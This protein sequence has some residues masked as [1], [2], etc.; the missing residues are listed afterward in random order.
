MDCQIWVD[1]ATGNTLLIPISDASETYVKNELS[2][3]AEVANTSLSSARQAYVLPQTGDNN[4][5]LNT[6]LAVICTHAK[7][8]HETC[9]NDPGC[10]EKIR[11][12]SQAPALGS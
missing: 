2:G 1:P 6:L 8:N 7:I 12:I 9:V 4:T 10:D 11:L 3:I 5:K